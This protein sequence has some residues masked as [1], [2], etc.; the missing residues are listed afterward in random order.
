MYEEQ[1]NKLIEIIITQHRIEKNL[2][3]L[4]VIVKIITIPLKIKSP[5]VA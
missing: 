3:I 2:D 4:E 1:I 5:P